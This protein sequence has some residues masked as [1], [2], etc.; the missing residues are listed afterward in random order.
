MAKKK[1]VAKKAAKK[2]P[3]GAAAEAEVTSCPDQDLEAAA[4]VNTAGES[5]ARFGEAF[6]AAIEARGIDIR[7]LLNAAVTSLQHEG[8]GRDENAGRGLRRCRDLFIE[9]DYNEMPYLRVV[10]K[11]V[12]VLT[13]HRRQSR[14]KDSCSAGD[15]FRVFL[16]E[17]QQHGPYDPEDYR[18]ARP[19]RRGNVFNLARDPGKTMFNDRL[20]DLK[21]REWLTSAATTRSGGERGYRL[22]ED[23]RWLF[24]GWP[25]VEGLRNTPP[26]PQPTTE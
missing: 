22:S 24:N 18:L 11:V 14:G 16:T 4:V 5:A 15:V 6:L 19:T 2:K 1:N 25:E 23:G 10:G 26:P 17:I 3:S 12:E 13:V 21:E 8:V 20:K 9:L 7:E